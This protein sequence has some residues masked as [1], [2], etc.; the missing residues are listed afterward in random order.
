[1]KNK[2]WI[3]FL[4]VTALFAC[5]KDTFTNTAD[6]VGISKVTY[7]VVLTLKGAPIESVVEGDTYTDPGVDAKANGET[8][9]Y[10]TTGSVDVNTPGL[11]TLNYSSVNKDGFAS[12]VSRTVV[13]ITAHETPGTDISGSYDYV[14]S[15]TYTSTITKVAEGVYTTDNFWSGGTII[16]GT[17]VCLN[18]TNIIFPDQATAYGE[19]TASSGTLSSTGKLV[20]DITIASQGIVNSLRNWQKQ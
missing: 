13:V 3:L 2:L 12:S 6:Q 4:L 8:V 17:F 11:Y 14:G 19:L 10:T 15:S 16:P 18:G 5:N 7:Y 20:Y 1:M 9:E